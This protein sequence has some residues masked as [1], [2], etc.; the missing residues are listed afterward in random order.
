MDPEYFASNFI[1]IRSN[2]QGIFVNRQTQLVQI[3]IA[4][5]NK[6]IL[7]LVSVWSFTLRY[8]QTN[9]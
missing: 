4:K 1:E 5:F 8:Y 9:F 3:V 2:S 6:Q 7:C